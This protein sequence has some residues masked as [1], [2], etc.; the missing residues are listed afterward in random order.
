[1]R[2]PRFWVVTTLSIFALL[3]TAAGAQG[4]PVTTITYALTVVVPSIIQLVVDESAQDPGGL[5]VVRVITND[6]AI[7]ARS[8]AGVVGE[9]VLR[10]A[11]EGGRI[12]HAKGG[13]GD[14]VGGAALPQVRYTQVTP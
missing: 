2:H 13:E 14:P 5:P 8:A 12:D 3:P 7:R 10:G 11:L 1:M 4:R 9:M 6:R